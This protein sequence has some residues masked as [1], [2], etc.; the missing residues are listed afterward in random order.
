[1]IACHSG[2]VVGLGRFDIGGW[3]AQWGKLWAQEGLRGG[4][5]ENIVEI[6]GQIPYDI[7]EYI[8]ISEAFDRRLVS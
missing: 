4:I 8:R 3:G 6:R 2:L 1:M 7:R 5:S